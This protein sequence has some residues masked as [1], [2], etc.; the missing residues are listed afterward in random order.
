MTTLRDRLRAD[1]APW[2]ERV[3]DAYSV[4]DLRQTVDLGRFLRSQL[5]VLLAVRCGPGRHA[6]DAERLRRSMIGALQADLRHLDLKAVRPATERRLDATAVHY[7]LLGSRLGT[8]VLHRRWLGAT[9]AAV[10]GAG[11]YLG[12]TPPT[13]AWRKFC[14]E[15]LQMPDQGTEADRITHDACIL[16]DLH[17]D[18]LPALAPLR[19][20]ESDAA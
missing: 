10:A 6:E 17:L 3:D 1:T 7:I 9:D 18:V 14:A 11:R 8:R 4:L 19:Q 13:A 2:H 15:L 12:T 16:F 5:S 20:G